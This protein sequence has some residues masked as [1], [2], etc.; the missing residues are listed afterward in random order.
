MLATYRDWEKVL[1]FCAQLLLLT[2]LEFV[3]FYSTMF[4][5]FVSKF[6]WSETLSGHG[7]G[8]EEEQ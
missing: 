7:D 6:H 8:D 3:F 2:G 1:N 4:E 5:V